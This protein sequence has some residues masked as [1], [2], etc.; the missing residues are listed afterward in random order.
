MLFALEPLIWVKDSGGIG[1]RIED[2]VLITG[3]GHRVLS[4]APYADALLS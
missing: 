1:V 4:R 2:M 3:S